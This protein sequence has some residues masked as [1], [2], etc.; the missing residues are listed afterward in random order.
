MWHFY[1]RLLLSVSAVNCELPLQRNLP[2]GINKVT[3]TLT[4][5]PRVAVLSVKMSE[6][7]LPQ[8]CKKKKWAGLCC[9]ECEKL[10]QVLSKMVDFEDISLDDH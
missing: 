8:S 7:E 9:F 4:L 1:I 6:S 2:A 5:V 3:L 10:K